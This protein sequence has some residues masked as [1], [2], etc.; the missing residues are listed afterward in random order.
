MRRPADVLPD[1]YTNGELLS[2]VGNMDL[3]LGIRLHALIFAGV[4]GVPMIGL[5]YDPKIDRF[6][7]SVGEDSV[8]SLESVTVEAILQAVPGARLRALCGA[9][10]ELL[11]GAPAP[12]GA[13]CEGERL[14]EGVWHQPLAFR[15]HIIEGRQLLMLLKML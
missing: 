5:S 6:L 3:L 14:A 2:L 10:G 4:M 11:R 15:Q 7:A 12:A 9:T 13:I 8:G 1:G